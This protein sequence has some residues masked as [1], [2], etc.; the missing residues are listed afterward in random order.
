MATKRKIY[1]PSI[2]N[3]GASSA[4]GTVGLVDLPLYYKYHSI[5]FE[6]LDGGA[7][8]QTI[9]AL[10]GDIAFKVNANTKRIHSAADLDHA[11]NVNGTEY[12]YQTIGTGATQ[13]QILKMFFA[14]PWRKDPNQTAAL[15]ANL[16]P[17]FGV[18]SAQ[19]QITLASAM[20]ATGSLVVYAVVELPDAQPPQGGALVKIVERQSIQASGTSIDI[21]NLPQQ[22]F[23]QT[24]LLKHP[25]TGYIIKATLKAN[26]T[27][28]REL[29]RE[30]VIADLSYM[31]MNPANSTSAGAFGF[32]LVLDD[33]DPLNSALAASG[34]NF[35]L[36]L[37]FSQSAAGNVVALIERVQLGW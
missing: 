24:V 17:A 5:G 21:T 37:D 12:A 6:Y 8:P 20:P 34:Q 23:Y 11:N 14:E 2:S 22:G 32:D 4:A 19:L 7:T 35:Q 33:D 15:A 31:S 26:G 25:S 3:L 16:T 13:K 10:I 29:D 28:I 30:A 27:V 36:R 9:L 18:N 1:L